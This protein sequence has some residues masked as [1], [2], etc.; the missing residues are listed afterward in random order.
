MEVVK[1]DDRDLAVELDPV[2]LGVGL[3]AANQALD[4]PDRALQATDEGVHRPPA[5]GRPGPHRCIVFALHLLGDQVDQVA[6]GPRL[7]ALQPDAPVTDGDDP[8]KLHHHA[9]NDH[10][11]LGAIVFGIGEQKRQQIFVAELLE[12]PEERGDAGRAG[13]DI[14][15]RGPTGTGRGIDRHRAKRLGG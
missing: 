13:G 6:E 9:V 1:V 5:D 4:M 8:P 10:R 15:H 7:L 3:I 12:R 11:V 14:G 2:L